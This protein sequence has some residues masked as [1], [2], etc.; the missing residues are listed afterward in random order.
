MV[1][2]ISDRH[3]TITVVPLILKDT[4]V[5]IKKKL[6]KS[7]PIWAQGMRY[8]HIPN[9]QAWKRNVYV[10]RS[11]NALTLHVEYT[12]TID[13]DHVLQL[14]I[15]QNESHILGRFMIQHSNIPVIL[16]PPTYTHTC[17]H[18]KKTRV[19]KHQVLSQTQNIEHLVSQSVELMLGNAT[20][21]SSNLTLP[22]VD[23]DSVTVISTL[24]LD[25]TKCANMHAFAFTPVASL[26]EFVKCLGL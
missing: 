1:L 5:N 19:Y 18:I 23:A 3:S 6:N 14:G 4:K 21:Q 2:K 7:K 24:S 11:N 13:F 8:E 22:T 15:N 9:Q 20:W 16:Q 10:M 12:K 17:I 25:N 26:Q